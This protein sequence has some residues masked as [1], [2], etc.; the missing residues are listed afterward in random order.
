MRKDLVQDLS[1]QEMRETNG[2]FCLLIKLVILKLLLCGCS[3]GS[4]PDEPS[5]P[6]T[7]PTD[8]GED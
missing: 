3:C 4:K 8:P 1:V 2:G 5:T 6:P 7:G